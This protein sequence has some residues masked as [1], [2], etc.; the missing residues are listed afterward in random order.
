MKTQKAMIKPAAWI[1]HINTILLKFMIFLFA[2]YQADIF[3]VEL[4]T[5]KMER[6]DV[7]LGFDEIL[8]R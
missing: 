4:Q 3:F 7:D 2:R 8:V 1:K 6:I 5:S